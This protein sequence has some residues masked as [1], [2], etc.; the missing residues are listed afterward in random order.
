MLSSSNVASQL[1]QELLGVYLRNKFDF[2][3]VHEIMN[4]QNIEYIT[5]IYIL[6][7]LSSVHFQVSYKLA[8]FLDI[9]KN[10]RHNG[11]LRTAKTSN[12]RVERQDDA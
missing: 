7:Y 10:T 6:Y 4:R 9:L 2:L 12:S 8:G 5:Y 11:G 3:S 1:I